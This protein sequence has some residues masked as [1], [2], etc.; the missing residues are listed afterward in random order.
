MD[1]SAISEKQYGLTPP[2]GLALPTEAEL[3]SAEAL[4]AELHKQGTFEHIQETQ[5]R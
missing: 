3:R 2:L 5:K 4:V 1:A